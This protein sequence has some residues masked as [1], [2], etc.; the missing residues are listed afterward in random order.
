MRVRAGSPAGLLAVVPHL[1]GFI[2]QDS[3]VVM[4]TEPPRDRLTGHAPLRPA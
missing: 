1:L 4:G 2:P 3:L